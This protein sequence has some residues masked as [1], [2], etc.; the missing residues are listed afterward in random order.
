MPSHREIRDL[1]YTAEQMF[2]VVADVEKYPQFLP[3]CSGLRVHSREKTGDTE[4]VVAEMLVAYH[5]VRERYTSRVTL[6]A[7]ALTVEAVHIQGPFDHLDNHWRFEP[8]PTGCRVHFAI[9][10]A[11]KNRILSALAGVAFDMVARK[12]AD[13][14]AKRAGRLYGGEAAT[15]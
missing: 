4:I 8:T 9:A 2:A 1:P 14:F 11:F 6:D 12:M 15:A 10:F 3:W 5:G 13:A 7:S